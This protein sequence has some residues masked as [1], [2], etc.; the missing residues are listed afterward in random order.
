MKAA[1]IFLLCLLIYSPT[2]LANIDVSTDS[3]KVGQRITLTFGTTVDTLLVTYRPNSSVANR[4]TISIN[5][6]ATSVEWAS[7]YPGLVA[8]AYVDKSQSPPARVTRNLSVRFDGLSVSG[9]VVMLLAGTILFGGAA[10]AFRSL[11][12]HREETGTLDLDP[13]EM[14]DT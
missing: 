3:P 1:I 12:R 2:A 5:P 8:L 7:A 10:T 6:P 14:P 13:E 9:L 11:F 4:D